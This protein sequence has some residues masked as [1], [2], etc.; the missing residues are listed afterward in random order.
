MRPEGRGDATDDDIR[1]SEASKVECRVELRAL[2]QIAH[3]RIAE[4][5][6]VALPL[7]ERVNLVRIDIE[8]DRRKSRPM[9]RRQQRQPDVTQTDD[10]DDRGGGINFRLE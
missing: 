2:L 7:F 8:T 3:Q 10:A 1:F 6:E 5:L 4:V 9:K